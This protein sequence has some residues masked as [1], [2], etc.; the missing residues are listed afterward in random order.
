MEKRSYTYEPS[1][2]N[3]KGKDRMRFELGD[4]MVEGEA[5]TAALTDQEI[6]AMLELHPS[7]WKKAKLALVESLCRR[8]SYEVDT[9]VGPMT[10]GLG[11]RVKVWREMY[12]Q[13]KAELGGHSVPSANP[14][15][16]GGGSYFYTG[17]QSNPST[18][19]GGGGRGVSKTR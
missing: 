19:K 12:E 17:M 5:E 2:I 1:D 9:K 18:G 8:F 3:K 11:D 6:E 13:L 14:A 10:L 15:A 7:N 16:I 4:T